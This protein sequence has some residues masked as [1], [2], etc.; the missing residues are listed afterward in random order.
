VAPYGGTEARFGTNTI[1][2]GFPTGG[3]VPVIRDVE[4]AVSSLLY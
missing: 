4:P 1:C 2:F 3:D